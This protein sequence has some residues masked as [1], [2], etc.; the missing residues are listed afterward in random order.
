MFA[1]QSKNRILTQYIAVMCNVPFRKIRKA[2]RK[3]LVHLAF[4]ISKSLR[5]L[6]STGSTRPPALIP[7]TLGEV[8][9]DQ[10]PGSLADVIGEQ[11]IHRRRIKTEEKA[12]AAVWGKDFYSI[13]CRRGRF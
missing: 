6:Y 10:R 7:T 5:S 13:P 12:V 1:H 8:E 9:A 4:A 3:K 2:T 11:L